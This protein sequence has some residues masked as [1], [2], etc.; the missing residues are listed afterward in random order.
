MVGTAGGE[1]GDG[2]PQMIRG[3]C[4]WGPG[5]LSEPSRG[6]CWAMGPT[7]PSC[8]LHSWLEGEQE[9]AVGGNQGYGL[10]AAGRAA[11]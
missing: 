8:G 5:T 11:E 10:P 4:S 1:H 9:E 3:R 2:K 7:G 6:Q